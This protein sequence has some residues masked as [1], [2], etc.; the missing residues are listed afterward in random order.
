M[1]LSACANGSV[2]V[3][4]DI[5]DP[6]NKNADKFYTAGEKF[7]Y[8]NYDI[9]NEKTSYSLLSTI[10]TPST[11]KPDA[12]PAILKKDRPYAGFLAVEYEKQFVSSPGVVDL[13]GIQV[14]CVGGSCSLGKEIQQGFHKLIKQGRPNWTKSDELKNEP[15]FILEGERQIELAKAKYADTSIIGGTRLG[16]IIDDASLGGKVRLGYNLD[17]FQPR[18]INFSLSPQTRPELTSYL[19][20]SFTQRAV[21]WNELLDGSMFQSEPHTVHHEPFV[22]DTNAGLTIG[23][24]LYKLSYVYVF[25]SDEWTTQNQ[26]FAFGSL[27]FQW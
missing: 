16:P 22:T 8:D 23:Y 5:L 25:R 20:G 4:N 2:H 3:D 15:G 13:L 11:K 9:P 21:A 7:S 1:C 12:D 27:T 14:G 24:G 19:F 26:G 6:F 10:Y 18:P 17:T